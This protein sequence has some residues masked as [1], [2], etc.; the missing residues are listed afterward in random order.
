MITYS[1]SLTRSTADDNLTLV[2]IISNNCQPHVSVCGAQNN[3]R[4]Q[5]KFFKKKI[6]LKFHSQQI[7]KNIPFNYKLNFTEQLVSDF[8]FH[9]YPH[10]LKGQ[11]WT[12]AKVTSSD[13]TQPQRNV[14]D[15]KWRCF[16][17]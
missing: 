7:I 10:I 13:A 6:Y 11:Q 3:R 2:C 5:K 16:I 12:Y 15:S 17:S 8:F 4:K 9:K 14:I 1:G